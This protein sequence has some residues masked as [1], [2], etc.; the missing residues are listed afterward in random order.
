MFAENGLQKHRKGKTEVAFEIF[1][2]VYV[3]IFNHI[4][5]T[6]EIYLAFSL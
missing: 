6:R 5:N 1:S 3:L 2:D 4:G